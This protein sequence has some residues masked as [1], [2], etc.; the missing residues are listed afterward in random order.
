MLSAPPASPSASA[1]ITKRQRAICAGILTSM[2]DDETLVR[3]LANVLK[4][5]IPDLRERKRR[6][7]WRSALTIEWTCGRLPEDERVLMKPFGDQGPTIDMGE[8][9]PIAAQT[10]EAML[11]RQA[12]PERAMFR[13]VKDESGGFLSLSAF[14]FNP[15]VDS[16]LT[17][18]TRLKPAQQR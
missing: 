4:L 3:T 1:A 9:G 14:R 8:A 6:C 10:C 18:T 5:V 15:T 16:M 2:D 17:P 11:L 13:T 12:N 7:G